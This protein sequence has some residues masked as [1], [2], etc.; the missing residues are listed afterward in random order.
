MS[1]EVKTITGSEVRKYLDD[2]ARL[3]IQIFSDFPYLYDG[4]VE[5][6]QE[7]L[8][9]YLKASDFAVVLAMDGKK[10]IGASTCL[11]LSE[12]IDEIKNPV[13]QAGY[14]ADDILYF[15]ESVLDKAFRGQGIGKLFFQKREAHAHQLK[16]KFASFCAVERPEDHPLRPENYQ[17]LHAFW[18]KE[19]YQKLPEVRTTLSWKDV[20]QQNETDKELTFWMKKLL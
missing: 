14:D 6:E 19:G 17:P 3:R 16:K 2:V 7:Y 20:D 5:H 4:N 12:E 15:G 10:V 9:R 11:P 8:G 13:L 1:V 18:K